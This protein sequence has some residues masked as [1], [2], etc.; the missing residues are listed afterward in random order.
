[1]PLKPQS[2]RNGVIITQEHQILDKP[3]IIQ[4]S[5]E[6]SELQTTF[7]KKMLKQGGDCKI[8]GKAYS[9]NIKERNDLDSKGNKPL[10]LPPIPGERTF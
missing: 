2:I 7:F 9:I 1:M 8:N 3:S 4:I 5:E 6:W 10:N